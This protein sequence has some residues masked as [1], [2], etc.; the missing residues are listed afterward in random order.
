MNSDVYTQ[1]LFERDL[2][3]AT[4]NKGYLISLIPLIFASVNL[5]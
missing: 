2:R 4:G 1:D 5:Y 3:V